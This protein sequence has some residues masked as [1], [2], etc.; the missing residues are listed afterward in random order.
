MKISYES[1]LDDMVE[2]QLRLYFR[3]KTYQRSKW[4]TAI[5]GPLVTIVVFWV[6]FRPQST[7]A[8]LFTVLGGL[9]LGLI[10]NV[11][12]FKDGIKKRIR[13]YVAREMKDKPPCISE[14][15]VTE[16]KIVY[17]ARNV[18]IGFLLSDLVSITEDPERMELFFG[19]DK[20]LCVIPLRAFQSPE[21]KSL[22]L[23]SLKPSPP[24]LHCP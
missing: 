14:Y 24:N 3:S 9:A 17:T 8:I 23:A 7:R 6:F 11:L 5:T 21:E 16:D 22:F 1:T 13:K 2:P 10:T 19:A 12:T 20:G 18:T 4:T 15:T